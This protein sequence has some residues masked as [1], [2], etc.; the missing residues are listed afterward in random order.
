M[1]ED[2]SIGDYPG[3]ATVGREVSDVHERNDVCLCPGRSVELHVYGH[4]AILSCQSGSACQ[5]VKPSYYLGIVIIGTRRANHASVIQPQLHDRVLQLVHFAAKQA[6]QPGDGIVVGWSAGA[7]V[8]ST[9]QWLCSM[10]KG[11]R[12]RA[13]AGIVTG[14]GNHT[15]QN[16]I[17]TR[18]YPPPPLHI[19]GLILILSIPPY[20]HRLLHLDM[21]RRVAVWAHTNRIS[22]AGPAVFL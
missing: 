20:H 19:P 14:N 15:I 17:V 16:R 4:R 10:L 3:E 8:D 6:K 9:R 12:S 2:G 22:G 11:G 13:R 5:Q 21:H 1:A 7:V 18:P